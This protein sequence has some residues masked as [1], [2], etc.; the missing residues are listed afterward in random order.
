MNKQNRKALFSNAFVKLKAPLKNRVAEVFYR[1]ALLKQIDFLQT[2]IKSKLLKSSS[3]DLKELPSFFNSLRKYF[4]KN[5]FKIIEKFLNLI[6]KQAKKSFISSFES[7]Y[8]NSFSV[9]FNEKSFK[10]IL[11]LFALQNAQLITS[12]RD[13]YLNSIANAVYNSVTTGASQK[14]LA[15]SLS[16]SLGV[17]QRR[18]KLIARDQSAKL[19]ESL[20]R[21]AQENAGIEF[22]IWQTAN[23]ERVSNGF[24]GHKHLDGKIYKYKDLSHLPIIDSK[25][26]RGL[27]GD[28][29]NCRCTAIPVI[30][31]NDAQIKQNK[32]GDWTIYK[33]NL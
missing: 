2:K 20:S 11:K 9:P 7:V 1:K 16:K 8:K 23:D 24:G 31:S 10:K 6:K 26:T 25:G 15:K 18:I 22:F 14:T 27:P 3:F 32:D 30:L 29:V 28:R 4:D 17:T 33:G 12:V 13:T 21:K 19:N 5:S